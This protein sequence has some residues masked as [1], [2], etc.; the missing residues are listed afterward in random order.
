MFRFPSNGKT[1][2]KR[3]A[4]TC[5]GT[6]TGFNSLQTGTHSA[7]S[8][9]WLTT[10]FNTI[11][12]RFPSNGNAEPT[13]R[14]CLTCFT[15]IMSFHSLQTGKCIAR[16]GEAVDDDVTGSAFPFPSNGNAQRFDIMAAAAEIA[17]EFP[18][19]SSGNT[20]PKPQQHPP[21]QKPKGV[22][23]PFI[24]ESTSQASKNQT[25]RFQTCVFPFPSYGKAYRKVTARTEEEALLKA[26][27]FPSYG[28]AH[29]KEGLSKIS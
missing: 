16:L 26:F 19:P 2:I 1:E 20:Y 23:I 13:S 22:S 27:P 10:A 8:G 14:R 7:S 9:V 4:P 29:R 11:V 5:S 3:T 12:F 6:I 28:N 15:A 18:F 21:S 17:L 24:R 25:S